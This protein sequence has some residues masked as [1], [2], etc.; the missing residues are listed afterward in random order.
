MLVR[1]SKL[2]SNNLK[3]DCLVSCP[4]RRVG[5]ERVRMVTCGLNLLRHGTAKAHA[6]HGLYLARGASQS[7]RP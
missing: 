2:L 4:Y 6:W 5:W 7:R 3:G 1:G